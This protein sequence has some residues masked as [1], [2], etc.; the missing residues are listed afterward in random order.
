MNNVERT[1][2]ITSVVMIALAVLVG[3]PL[4]YIVVN[5]L[6]TQQEMAESPLAL[7]TQLFLDNYPQSSR[8]C[9]SGRAS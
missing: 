4:Y 1:S 8:R 9:R 6:K 2:P 5:T 3:V 7:P